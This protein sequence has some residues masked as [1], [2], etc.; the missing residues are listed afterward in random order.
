[1]GLYNISTDV[2]SYCIMMLRVF[3]RDFSRYVVQSAHFMINLLSTIFISS[4]LMVWLLFLKFS[5][6]EES[7][8]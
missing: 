6:S 2:F 7:P 3:L 8:R 4:N 5:F 1:M